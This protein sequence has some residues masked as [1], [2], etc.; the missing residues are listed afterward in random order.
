ML[1]EVIRITL[2]VNAKLE[3]SIG[4]CC[5]L[6]WDIC[7]RKSEHFMRCQDLGIFHQRFFDVLQKRQT[8]AIFFYI[9]RSTSNSLSTSINC[10]EIPSQT[11]LQMPGCIVEYWNRFWSR[12]H[13][14][15]NS[16]ESFKCETLLVE[17]KKL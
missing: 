15:L 5:N 13:S 9:D 14:I 2:D 8:I 11:C 10:T 1:I 6:D 12:L 16:K 17:P 3:L 4:E 7:R